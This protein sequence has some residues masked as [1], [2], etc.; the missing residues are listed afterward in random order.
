MSDKR[1][2]T[3]GS[4]DV[5]SILGLS[6]WTPPALTWARLT[7]I[8]A[9]YSTGDT[10]QTRRGRML[11]GALLDEWARLRSPTLMQRGPS[12]EDPPFIVDEWRAARPDAL[13]EDAS[14]GRVVVE[15]K[16]TR[17]WE[18]WGPDGSDRV[19]VYYAAQVA[20]QLSVLD[21]PRAEVIAYSPLDDGIRVYRVE[22]DL[23]VEAALVAR[24]RAWMETHVWADEPVQPAPL[25]YSVVAERYADGGEKAEWLD[26]TDE[27]RRVAL[28]LLAVR[29]EIAKLQEREEALKARLC[30]RIGESYGLKGVCTWGRVRGRETVSA[31]DLKSGW[32]DIYAQ[33]AK[34][35]ATS[36]QF[37]LTVKEQAG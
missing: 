26:A 9:R 33:V 19:P 32:P 21:I 37:R 1:T 28:D 36:R 4:S 31:S 25:P 13:A 2:I 17:S 24:V 5:P 34:R 14:G 23:R 11:E 22:R 7:G 12:I 18:A 20:W 8:V 6:P 16:T 35:G 29:E 3:V 27:D 10:P 15:A 30:E